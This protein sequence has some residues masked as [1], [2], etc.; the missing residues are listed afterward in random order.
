MTVDPQE[1]ARLVDAAKSAGQEHIFCW[2][3]ELDENERGTLLAQVK[4]IDFKLLSRLV[5]SLLHEEQSSRSDGKLEPAEV[6]RVPTTDEKKQTEK[7]ARERGE[8]I[9]SEGKV[10]AVLVA[11][12][13][14][15]RM[16]CEGPK[17]V[18]PIGPVSGKCFFELYAEKIRAIER[19]YGTVFPLYIMTSA[20]NDEATKGFFQDHDYF[21]LLPENVRFVMQDMLPAVDFSGKI[22][23][24]SKSHIFMSP[25]GHGASLRMLYDRGAL[26]DMKSRGLEIIYHFQVDN[27]LIA[28]ADPVFIGYHD[29]NGAEM[30]SKMVD[31]DSPTEGVGIA[32]VRDGTNVV[33]E[34]SDIDEE[35]ANERTPDGRFRF[36]AGN[37]A[38][39][40]INVSFVER[41][42]P[43]ADS[44]PF[45]VARKRV[46]YVNEHGDRCIPEEVNGIKFESFVFDALPYASKIVHME[47]V[48]RNEYYPVK[49]G[50]GRYS[51]SSAKKWISH[52]YGR[53][54]ESAGI[55]VP[56]DAS[57][58]VAALIEISPLYA[59]DKEELARKVDRNLV[60]ANELYLSDN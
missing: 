15:T 59:L 53:W 49:T 39:H 43:I 3:D 19:R 1:K 6:I 26:A 24:D 60:V 52:A 32:C 28:L 9:L 45:H 47:I 58:N 8:E 27:P 21:G 20:T 29:L 18:V 2:W 30:S 35:T 17:G 22:I 57:G 10:C 44:M 4:S 48:R 38:Q 41:M 11:G 13:Q 51:P 56:R 33:I 34:Y 5:N 36:W 55:S 12:G 37:I 25:T 7:R 16:G 14:A 42:R 23:M 50:G 46:P 54:L 31:K 40:V